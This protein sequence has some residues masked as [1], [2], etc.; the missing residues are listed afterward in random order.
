MNEVLG[1]PIGAA[2]QEPL[3]EAPAPAPAPAAPGPREYLVLESKQAGHWQEK[4]KVSADSNEDA[5]AA[6]KD[7]D[8]TAKYVVIASRNWSPKSPEIETVTTV[9]FK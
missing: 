9:K 3:E 4:E 8:K 6:I 1:A 5:L 2:P 7:P